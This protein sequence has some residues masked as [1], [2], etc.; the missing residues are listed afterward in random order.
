ME[1]IE[2]KIINIIS[3][4][5]RGTA[6]FSNNFNF[7]E[8]SK[9]IVFYSIGNIIYNKLMYEQKNFFHFHIHILTDKAL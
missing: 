1:S 7:R 4:R 3:K 5:G 9:S 6:F 2:N 8:K